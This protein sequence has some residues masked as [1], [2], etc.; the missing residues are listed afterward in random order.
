M[1]VKTTFLNDLIEEDGHINQLR[2]FEVRGNETYGCILNNSLYGINQ[3]PHAWCSK[4]EEYMLSLGLT[5][6]TINPK[7]Y[8]LFD[9]YDVLVLV[10]Y[11]GDWILTRSL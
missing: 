6:A 1:D 2:G 8:Y 7:F 9:V 11:V 5:K 3:T 4:I 10:I